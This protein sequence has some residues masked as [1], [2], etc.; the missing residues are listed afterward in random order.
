MAEQ[1][2][3]SKPVRRRR[4]QR[5]ANDVQPSATVI[6][7]RPAEVTPL[8]LE[9]AV[10]NVRTLLFEVRGLL[11]I[12]SDVLLYGDDADAALHAEV[13]KSA[14]GWVNEA[15]VLL[16]LARLQPLIEAIRRGGGGMPPDDQSGSGSLRLYQV[17]EPT[18]V[19]HV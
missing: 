12:L 5:I 2:D 15:T 16:D 9:E 8:T 17:K 10:E 13:A 6:A 3:T 19:Y 4:N 1:D 11:H 14:E 7:E 18:P